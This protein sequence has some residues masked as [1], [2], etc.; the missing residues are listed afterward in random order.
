[1]WFIPH[2]R[3]MM[4]ITHIIRC[5][6]TG[7]LLH[8]HWKFTGRWSF[9]LEFETERSLKN[10]Y[11]NY[12]TFLIKKCFLGIMLAFHLCSI[13]GAIIFRYR[14][15]DLRFHTGWQVIHHW[16]HI[17]LATW[18][19]IGWSLKIVR[20]WLALSSWMFLMF[21]WHAQSW[22]KNQGGSGKKTPSFLALCSSRRLD[23]CWS[24]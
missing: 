13:A 5:K 16:L 12:F 15:Q 2:V 11:S 20:S 24:H 1:M 8:G 21:S 9:S 17:F 23:P 7:Q 22:S 4:K 3:P 18:A 19:P 14:P 10:E 6:T